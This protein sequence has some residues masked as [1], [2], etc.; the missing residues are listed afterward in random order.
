MTEAATA[1]V[2]KSAPHYGAAELK[3]FYQKYWMIGFGL[4]V[5]I[6]FVLDGLPRPSLLE[7]FSW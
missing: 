5:A 7:S 2:R 6:H 4:A 1:T 3:T